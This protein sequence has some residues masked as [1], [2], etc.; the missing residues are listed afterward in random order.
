MAVTNVSRTHKGVLNL[1]LLT[2]W[3]KGKLLLRMH[4]LFYFKGI[5]HF[6]FNRIQSKRI[7]CYWCVCLGYFCFDNYFSLCN[8]THWEDTGVLKCS[9]E[10]LGGDCS[11]RVRFIRGFV[12]VGKARNY[13]KS[14]VALSYFK[15]QVIWMQE[16]RYS[17]IVR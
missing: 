10:F 13:P 11:I 3:V 2:G 5:Y 9:F 4:Y 14:K 7:Y 6:V 8:K 15:G 17:G 16:W 1:K 12:R